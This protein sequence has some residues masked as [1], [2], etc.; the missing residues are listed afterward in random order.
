[1]Q[2][3]VSQ[4]Q[5]RLTA[6]NGKLAHLNKPLLTIQS[7]GGK[8]SLKEHYRGNLTVSLTKWELYHFMIGFEE[9]LNY[10]WEN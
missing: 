3:T 9:A 5:A 4:I 2:I 7:E 8:Y 10:L 6:I 1:M